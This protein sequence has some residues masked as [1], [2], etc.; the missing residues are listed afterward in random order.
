MSW[1][2]VSYSVWQFIRSWLSWTNG[3]GLSQ[4][5]PILAVILVVCD[6]AVIL[7]CR[8]TRHPHGCGCCCCYL[9][10]FHVWFWVCFRPWPFTQWPAKANCQ[11]D[12]RDSDGHSVACLP[13]RPFARP[14]DCLLV[15][16][17]C[18]LLLILGHNSVEPTRLSASI[19]FGL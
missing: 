6:L 7:T 12:K 8:H 13:V 10:S 1:I 4:L 15:C 2:A 5:Q 18:L 9:S 16:W 11:H 3:H 14:S 19:L 17:R